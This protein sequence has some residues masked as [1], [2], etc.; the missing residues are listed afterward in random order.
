[1]ISPRSR[2]A[3]VAEARETIARGSQSFA[4]ASRL[5]DRA[6]RERA[7]LLY[8]WCR[9]CD[10]M[11]DGQTLGHGRAERDPQERLAH[12]TALTERALAGE[13]VDEAPFEALRT[14]VAECSI[15][16]GFVRDHLAGFAADAAG[17]RPQTEADLLLYCY[18]VAGAVGCMMAVL[19]GV[20]SGD[21][22]T[23][24]RA[25]DLGVAFQLANIARDVREDAENGRCYLPADW[26]AQCGIPADRLMDGEHR[27]QLAVLAARLAALAAD[28]EASARSGA[29][30]L[31]FRARWA[32][33]SAASI[34][35]GIARETA[36]RGTGAWER[37]VVIRKR[38]KLLKLGTALGR[39]CAAAPERTRDGLWTRP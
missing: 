22:D 8:A 23:L 3:L 39:A 25:S 21:R 29:A 18:R 5:F 6:T 36:R 34:Y 7:W 28:Y 30:R 33:L 32:V 31:P 38:A 9:A 15:P 2:A 16:H 10:D 4:L 24:D 1:M 20:S 14:V 19:M 12:L 11:V 26:L 13:P 27:P 37:R 35:G 17:W